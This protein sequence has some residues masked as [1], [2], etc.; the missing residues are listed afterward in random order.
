MSVDAGDGERKESR[1]V[2]KL[3]ILDSSTF[4]SLRSSLFEGGPFET[5]SSLSFVLSFMYSNCSL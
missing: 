5:I 4:M 3:E 2:L 1:E